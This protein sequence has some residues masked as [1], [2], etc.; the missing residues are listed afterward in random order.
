[1]L[2]SVRTFSE[3]K[4]S[5]PLFF[6][7]F[8]W[9]NIMLNLLLVYRWP[10]CW[11]FYV[12]WKLKRWSQEFSLKDLLY[13]CCTLDPFYSDFPFKTIFFPVEKDNKPSYV[14]IESWTELRLSW[15]EFC[16]WVVMVQWVKRICRNMSWCTSLKLKLQPVPLVW[17]QKNRSQ[18]KCKLEN[19]DS[20]QV[21]QNEEY[22]KGSHQRYITSKFNL[23][24]RSADFYIPPSHHRWMTWQHVTQCSQKFRMHYSMCTWRMPIHQSFMTETS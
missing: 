10:D 12:Y 5:S 13:I 22:H 11:H 21:K 7:L 6:S 17:R 23:S 24:E 20:V 4:I 1:M 9:I 14:I 3:P 2:S 18:L 8:D 15:N 16:S 19:M